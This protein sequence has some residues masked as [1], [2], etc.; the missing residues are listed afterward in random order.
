MTHCLYMA[1]CVLGLLNFCKDIQSQIDPET[2]KNIFLQ[3]HALYD[4]G[5]FKAASGLL[6]PIENK[7]FASWNLLG[8]CLKKLNES[9]SALAAFKNAQKNAQTYDQFHK[10]EVEILRLKDSL[11]GT[12]LHVSTIESFIQ[13]LLFFSQFSYYN[14]CLSSLFGLLLP[15][16]QH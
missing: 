1:L 9:V 12:Q 5:D 11:Q 10:A 2:Y 8:M 6:K 7:G 4:K 15:C 14:S 3:A 13:R 16:A